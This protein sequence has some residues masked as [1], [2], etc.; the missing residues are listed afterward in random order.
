MRNIFFVLVVFFFL[1]G[2]AFA[3][4]YDEVYLF[5]AENN[6]TISRYWKDISGGLVAMGYEGNATPGIEIAAGA[7]ARISWNCTN[8]D[9]NATLEH[10]PPWSADWL[11]VDNR[12]AD[13]DGV[14]VM[15]ASCG[16]KL[17]N[18]ATKTTYRLHVQPGDWSNGFGEM[19]LR[20]GLSPRR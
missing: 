14:I 8:G 7:E 12:T 9:M 19:S 6:S 13:L 5:I 16:A 18:P 10:K 3:I 11:P 17:I 20:R 4:S 1:C 15:N 2:S